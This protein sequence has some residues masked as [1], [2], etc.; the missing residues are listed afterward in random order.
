MVLLPPAGGLLLLG[1]AVAQ[2]AIVWIESVPGF[3]DVGNGQS[4]STSAAK[5]SKASDTAA[6]CIGVLIPSRAIGQRPGYI[7]RCTRYGSPVFIP[8]GHRPADKDKA[9][10]LE[11]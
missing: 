6:V 3:A 8:D 9:T 11:G 1:N 10:K 4:V 2:D 5:G 7:D